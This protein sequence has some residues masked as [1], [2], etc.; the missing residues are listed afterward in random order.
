MEE[1]AHELENLI[2]SL[3][4]SKLQSARVVSLLSRD[5]LSNM[6]DDI[7]NEYTDEVSVQQWSPRFLGRIFNRH[8]AKE[9]RRQLTDTLFR[10][11]YDTELID[12]VRTVEL[13]TLLSRL[14]SLLGIIDLEKR[15]KI[16]YALLAHFLLCVRRSNTRMNVYPF[17][18]CWRVMSQEFLLINENL[19]E[20]TTNRH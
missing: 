2:D 15:S 10:A 16:A 18:I 1:P 8:D 20:P 7:V 4:F 14:Q 9:C 3:D 5:A 11:V 17:H 13:T 12:G 6:P 19:N